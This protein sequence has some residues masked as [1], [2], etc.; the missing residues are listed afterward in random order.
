MDLGLIFSNYITCLGTYYETFAKRKLIIFLH[1]N[2]WL[3]SLIHL[4][5][6]PNGL[7]PTH[8]GMST[9]IIII[10]I[11]NNL[12]QSVAVI[13]WVQHHYHVSKLI[14][15]SRHPFPLASFPFF[16]ILFHFFKKIILFYINLSFSPSTPLAPPTF[17]HPTLSTPQRMWDLPWRV[18]KSRTSL[19]GRTEGLPTVSWLSKV[20]LHREWAPKGLFMH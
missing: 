7:S 9:G 2:H 3:P 15:R 12:D 20:S 16:F 8:M 13:S 1:I 4:S 18:T 5:V 14:S 17:P 19:W 6:G 10:Q 11:L